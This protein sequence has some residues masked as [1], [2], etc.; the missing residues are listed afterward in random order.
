MWPQDF[1]DWSLTLYPQAYQLA[2]QAMIVRNNDPLFQADIP[3][4]AREARRAT[5]ELARQHQALT[6]YFADFNAFRFWIMAV[7]A[8]HTTRLYL[9]HRATQQRLN[10]LPLLERQLLGLVY[11]DRLMPS[12]VARLLGIPVIDVPARALQALGQV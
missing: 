4:L 2:F 12:E 7:V 1:I 9:L 5:F 10:Q 3:G 8:Q 6:G 11:V